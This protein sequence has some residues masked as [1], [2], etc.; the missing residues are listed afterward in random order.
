MSL[1][2]TAENLQTLVKELTWLIKLFRPELMSFKNF[3]FFLLSDF[4]TFVCYVYCSLIVNGL[5]SFFLVIY[6][7][8]VE[9][10]LNM[11]KR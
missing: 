1:V 7:M 4:V 2:D 11:M 10:F 9:K 6:I 3:L 5:C 8:V